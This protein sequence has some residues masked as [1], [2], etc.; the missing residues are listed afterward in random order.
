MTSTIHELLWISYLMQD[1]H[2]DIYIPIPLSC[3]SQAP[4]QITANLVF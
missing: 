3:N 2:I 1:L 4:L